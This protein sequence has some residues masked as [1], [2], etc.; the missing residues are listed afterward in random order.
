MR[1]TVIFSGSSHTAFVDRICD[2][3]GEKPGQV[4]LRKFSNGET[5]VSIQTSVRNQ[6][7][8]IVQS[9]SRKMNDSLMELLIMVSACKGSSA[10]S[11]TG[12][13][14]DQVCGTKPAK[15]A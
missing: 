1:Q 13:K 11:I 14:H 7:V 15:N 3:L 4:E 12:K 2:R 5:S 8:F 10:K 9:G 6:D